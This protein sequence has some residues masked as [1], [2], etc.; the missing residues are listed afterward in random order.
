MS[1]R[2]GGTHS[3]SMEFFRV[4]TTEALPVV[5]SVGSAEQQLA[6]ASLGCYLYAKEAT[7][8]I[9]DVFPR[10]G[11]A[12]Q[13]ISI[14]GTLFS[15]VVGEI[16]VGIGS[17]TCDVSHVNHTVIECTLRRGEATAGRYP[18]DVR[19]VGVGFARHVNKTRSTYEIPL[20]VHDFAPRNGSV[21]GG[22][23]IRI[24]GEGFSRLGPQNK[25]E[26][27]GVPCTPRTLK[28]FHCRVSQ[29]DSGFECAAT[30]TKGYELVWNAH[31]PSRDR[32]NS[33]WLDYSSTT[34][35]E[36]VLD[37]LKQNARVERA[38]HRPAAARTRFARRGRHLPELHGGHKNTTGTGD[39]EHGLLSAPRA[40]RATASGTG[41]WSCRT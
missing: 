28:N 22:D 13:L 21:L 26:V 4:K 1:T 33:E 38:R 24:W 8:T 7:P 5:V 18:V 6:S 16:E 25:V 23:I 34:Y 29:Y 19:V 41:A 36:C 20:K 30:S 2:V 37:D 10:K 14:A 17:A 31:A 9:T 32:A 40:T 3:L 11:A 15:D 27:A 39:A 12:G 35:I